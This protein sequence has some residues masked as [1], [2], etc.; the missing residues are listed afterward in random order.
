MTLHLNSGQFVFYVHESELPILTE[1]YQRTAPA[2]KM[3]EDGTMMSQIT[4]T[5]QV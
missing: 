1:W 5:H 4:P 2:S 3:A